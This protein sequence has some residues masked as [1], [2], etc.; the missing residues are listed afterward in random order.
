MAKPLKRWKDTVIGPGSAFYTLMEDLDAAKKPEER[1]ALQAQLKSEH[2]R[3][4]DEFH[5]H[6]PRDVW[7]RLK[8]KGAGNEA[9]KEQ[10]Q[11]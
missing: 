7:A 11:A 3:T 1:K 9:E 2:Q 6:F 4:D 10:T 8:S 5:K